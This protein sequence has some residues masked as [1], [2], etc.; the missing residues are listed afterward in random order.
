MEVSSRGRFC[1]SFE[2]DRAGVDG[3][4]K[5]FGSPKATNRSGTGWPPLT[6][7]RVAEEEK[8]S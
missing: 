5:L 8:T 7:E 4:L 3:S 6:R 2:T 1:R